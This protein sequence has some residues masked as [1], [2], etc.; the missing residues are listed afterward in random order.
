MNNMEHTGQMISDETGNSLELTSLIDEGTL[1][2]LQDSFSEMTGMAALTTDVHGIAVT[3]GSKFT[4]FCMKY[5]RQSKEGCKRCERCDKTGAEVAHKKGH[6]VAYHCHAGL[7]DYAAPILV[8][9][10]I[11]GSFIGG[12][13]LTTEPDYEQLKRIAGEL[14]IEYEPYR[15]ALSNVPIIDEERVEKAAEFLSVISHTLSRIAY[16]AYKLRQ[17]NLEL[18]KASRAKSDF[19]AN[20][21]HEIRTPMNAVLGLADMALREEMSP[22]AKAYLHQIK[23][24]GKN[25]LVII[26]DILDFSKI[27]SGKMDII[28]DTYEPY[29]ICNDL[30]G[31]VVS[32]I[33]EKNIEFIMDI[34]PELPRKMYGDNVR[35]HQV[36][37]NL[38]TNAVKYTEQGRVKLSISA[39]KKEKESV[40]LF[41]EIAD[42]GIGIK[43]EDQG[44]LFNSF[45]Q[46]DSK[47][48]RNVEGTGL[49]LALSNQILRLMGSKIQLESEYNKGSIFSFEL[50]QKIVDD[51]PTVR[52]LE[53]TLFALVKVENE[54]VRN[55][56]IKDLE[57]IG[58]EC[59]DL[60][61]VNSY[62]NIMPDFYILD[63]KFYSDEL[64][65]ELETLPVKCILL[66][67]FID[68]YMLDSRRVTILKKPIYFL[69]LYN[70]LGLTNIHITDHEDHEDINF[71]AP[72]AKIL[73]VDD[74][75]VNLTVAKG[76]IEPIRARIDT[77][78]GALEALDKLEKCKYDIVFM[79]H[80]MPRIDGVEATRLIH[81]RF[82][83]YKDMPIIALTANAIG[84]AKE[85][86]LSAGMD[87]FVAKP[88]EYIKLMSK[89]KKWLPKEK[90]Q[91]TDA[92]VFHAEDD[93]DDK[94]YGIQELDVKK[95]VSMLGGL[96][97]YKTVL[98]EYYHNID[99]KAELIRSHKE[100]GDIRSY[101]IEVH[102]LK[103]ASRQ[104][105]A[106]QLADLAAALE[107]AG[108]NHDLDYI[109]NNTKAMLE[110][111]QS[112]RDI[113]APYFTEEVIQEKK[114]AGE[115]ET[116]DMLDEMTEAIDSFDILLLDESI[117]KMEGYLY[118][119]EENQLL[120]QLIVAAETFDTDAML[121]I[122]EQWRQRF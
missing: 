121:Q 19:L 111:Y 113:L 78:E 39:K 40:L 68:N 7:V 33:G 102:A 76:L 85:M 12:Q 26:N 38:L 112:Y 49:G 10:I 5:T 44:K 71:I 103:S 65:K 119:E 86:F 118:S 99:K 59:I 108:N 52:P 48:N 20:M 110:Y 89:I 80:M 79:D 57:W 81:E 35:I 24:S 64:E 32:R 37:L 25:L 27:E 69:N 23:A 30:S 8:N 98:E 120:E 115:K 31:I 105:G 36:I 45:Q 94:V 93:M 42:T 66:E 74:N 28:E 55:Q 11:I 17:S 73:I 96:A 1:Q 22:L 70:T 54:Y 62:D 90:L 51:E 47:R 53:K 6:A 3:R 117:E 122:I 88:I 77:A 9:D 104:I 75:V 82:P 83:L 92:T 50:E 60:M 107:A 109:N 2:K 106:E 43:P 67:E 87:D 58:V 72:D 101:T 114:P 84:G 46:V 63:K 21:S 61:V 41:I 100:K 97:I 116:L 16:D 18:E 15:E 14:G 91:L 56:L 34:S 95:A 13:V 29:S 4:D